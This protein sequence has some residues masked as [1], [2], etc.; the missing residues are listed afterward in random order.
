MRQALRPN[1]SR[2][3]VA[4]FA[5][6]PAPVA[7]LNFRDAIAALG[8]TDALILDNYFPH[9]SYVELRRGY[10]EHVTGFASPVESVFDYAAPNGTAKL[11]A[12][13][14]TAIYDA[15]TA[16]AVGAAVVSSLTNARWQTVQFSTLG[17]D[18]L[19]AVNGADGV[20]TYNGSAW[21]TQTITGA[22]AANLVTV[23]S[24]KTRLWFGE[25]ASTKAWYLGTGAIAGAATALDLGYVWSLGGNLA[26]IV[27]IS[28][29]NT[30]GL[31]DVLCFVSTE[32][33]V[34][35]YVGTDPASANTWQLGGV[36]RIGRPTNRRAVARFGGDAIVMTDGG[37]VSLRQIVAV[38]LS[39]AGNVSITDKIN[40]VLGE[41]VAA[42][43][44][45]FGWEMIIYPAGTRLIVNAPQED[46]TYRQWVMNT[47]TGAWCRTIGMEA[48]SWSLMAGAPYFGGSTA[49]YQADTGATDNAGNIVGEV[50]GAFSVL[51]VPALKRMTMFR[52]T[53]TANGNP[54]PA[55]GIDV[56]F[57]DVTPT[58]VLVSSVSGGQWDVSLWDAAVFDSTT[59]NMREW[60]T[61]ANIG[62]TVA[63]RL[64]TETRGFDIQIT[65]FDLA[66]EAQG[67]AAL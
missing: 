61:V 40:R 53:L 39:Q 19:V 29:Q 18:F 34:A 38:D 7:G 51:G 60:T 46:G 44:S 58:D 1:R 47:L 48:L 41:Q 52:P 62:L 6:L 24:H 49:V 32:G 2:R 27:P 13:A 20:R 4:R 42:A 30:Q 59:N 57:S 21:A 43:A 22:T 63:P 35:A 11:F 14:G 45:T 28:F 64:R 25:N 31:D 16:G 55:V 37:V 66:F 54:S 33:E 10:T 5:S 36:Y 9:A 3:P 12:A 56:D 26:F 50:K 65:G 17:G 8:P 67:L 23:A 15:T